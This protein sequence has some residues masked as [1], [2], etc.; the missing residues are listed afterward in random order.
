[1]VLVGVIGETITELTEWIKPESRRKKIAKVSAL[2]LIVGLTG[3]LLGIRETQLEVASL[4][5]GIGDSQQKLEEEKRKRLQLAASLLDRDFRDQSGAIA[6]LSAIPPVSVVFEF[7]AERE[8]IK[9]A[10]Q[11]NFV[12]GKLNWKVSVQRPDWFMRDGIIV[13]PG[14]PQLSVGSASA[15]FDEW[16][17]L[18]KICEAVAKALQNSGLDATAPG[19]VIQEL[20]PNTILISIGEKPNHALEDAIKELGNPAPPT[21][22]PTGF[23]ER[24]GGIR[25]QFPDAVVDWCKNPCKTP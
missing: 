21:A 25:V 2:V 10:E 13:S 19:P 7:T 11:I 23:H 15:Q 17:R 1:M 18:Q 16:Q 14:R 22:M 3:D 6:E 24:L 12:V 5:K 4:T 20:P 8:V 9:T